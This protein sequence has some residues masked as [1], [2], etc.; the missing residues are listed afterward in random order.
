MKITM[1]GEKMIVDHILFT[2]ILGVI[3]LILMF[4]YFE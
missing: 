3:I 1:K 4:F 2:P